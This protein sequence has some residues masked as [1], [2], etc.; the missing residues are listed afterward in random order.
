MQ[1]K[2]IFINLIPRAFPSEIDWKG[3]ENTLISRGHMVKLTF[4]TYA[5]LCTPVVDPVI[6]KWDLQAF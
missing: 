3:L 1:I 5:N 4:I 2:L 6:V